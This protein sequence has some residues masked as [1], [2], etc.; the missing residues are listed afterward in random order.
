MSAAFLAPFAPLGAAPRALRTRPAARPSTVAPVRASA[1]APSPLDFTNIDLSSAGKTL[2]GLVFTPD[3]PTA[4]PET[5]A[6]VGFP[7]EVEDLINTQVNIEYTASYTYHALYAYFD[8]DAV[9]LPGFAKYFLKG[10]A[11]ERSHAHAFMEFQNRRGGKVVMK[12]VAV[13]E[14]Q[15]EALN[16][17]TSDALYAMELHLELERF[18]YEKL[19][20]LSKLAGELDDPTTCDFV[21]EYLQ[22]S[23]EDVKKSA[24]FVAQ[25][26]RIGTGHGVW[27]FDRAL[28]AE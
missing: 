2:S 25:L 7:K 19:L 26:K 14:M 5:R 10:S 12:P 15:F 13:P 22:E 9:A 24:E 16:D 17:G 21:D 20:A 6:R 4:T 28:A 8:R 27:D 18:V 1:E 11:D 23:A 3:S